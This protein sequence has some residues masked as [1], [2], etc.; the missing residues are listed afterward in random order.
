MIWT[1][2]KGQTIPIWPQ[3]VIIKMINSVSTNSWIQTVQEHRCSWTSWTIIQAVVPVQQVPPHHKVTNLLQKQSELWPK[4]VWH[5]TIQSVLHRLPLQRVHLLYVQVIL[6][7]RK[8]TIYRQRNRYKPWGAE[9]NT[10]NMDKMSSILPKFDAYPKFK[11]TNKLRNKVYPQKKRLVDYIE[12]T[13][14]K[15]DSNP[16]FLLRREEDPCKK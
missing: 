6:Q 8:N 10:L 16:R 2:P 4:L 13:V 11:Q 9:L 15:Q 3:T 14:I 12:H 7:N 5:I 1:I